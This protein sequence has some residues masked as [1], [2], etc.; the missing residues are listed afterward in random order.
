MVDKDKNG[1]N[2]QEMNDKI[3]Q[4]YGRKE[5][6]QLIKENES[7]FQSWE[8]K[9]GPMLDNGPNGRITNE[10][11]VKAFGLSINV[12]SGFRHKIPAKRRSVIMIAALLRLS[13]AET[14]DLLS[15]WAKFQKLYAKNP[16]DA[17]WMYILNNGGS[18]RPKELF[19][20][21]WKV[22]LDL[23]NQFRDGDTQIHQDT[24]IL[25]DQILETVKGYYSV[26]L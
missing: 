22:Y 1:E 25:E 15:R 13:V 12:V 14:S 20:A 23:R 18:D 24:L 3:L 2:T 8:D 9:I 4:C 7:H 26:K 5:F 11:M 17:I 16:E 21:Y 10:Q 6:E 19:E